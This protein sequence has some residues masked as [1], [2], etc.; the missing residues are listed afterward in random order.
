MPGA[1]PSAPRVR[2]GTWNTEFAKPGSVRAERVRPILAAPNCDILC[3]TEGYAEIFPD[4]GSAI[5]GGD[6]PGYPIV[7]G[8]KEVLLWSKEPW[9]NVEFGPEEMPK[10]RSWLGPPRRPLAT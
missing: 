10:A 9:E 4:G 2:I 7:E 8:Q 6:D 5:A 1:S 3:V